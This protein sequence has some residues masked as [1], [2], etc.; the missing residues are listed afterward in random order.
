MG[1][2]V[3][4]LCT[5]VSE[6]VCVCVQERKGHIILRRSPDTGRVALGHLAGK[7]GVYHTVSQGSPVALATEK[8][9]TEKGLFARTL[10]GCPRHTQPSR[11]FSEFL[12]WFFLM[13]LPFSALYVPCDR[14]FVHYSNC[15]PAKTY[16]IHKCLFS[17]FIS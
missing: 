4:K 1:S 12:L 14:K 17:E 13:F 6:C 16:Y 3:S 9:Q 11:G 5:C 15:T 2:L 8:K 10:A 7:T